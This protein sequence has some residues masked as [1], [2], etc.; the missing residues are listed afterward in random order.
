MTSINATTGLW[1]PIRS[2]R[3]PRL[4]ATQSNVTKI[5]KMVHGGISGGNIAE[6]RAIISLLRYI[7]D[8]G[9][10]VFIFC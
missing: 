6:T 4:V 1:D 8:L 3:E 10:N 2:W 5:V 7:S 9:Q